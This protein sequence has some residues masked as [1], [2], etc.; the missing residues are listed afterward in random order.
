[1]YKQRTVWAV[2]ET[3]DEYARRGKFRGYYETEKKAEA[4]AKGK[5]W[6]GSDG[7]VAPVFLLWVDGMETEFVLASPEPIKISME[8]DP[9]I[10]KEEFKASG[11]AKLLP[12][13]KIALGL[14]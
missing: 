11:L 8:V 9:V 4:Y 7:A 1:M 12:E 13:E 3:E 14:M 10:R 5:G 2:Y 6:Y